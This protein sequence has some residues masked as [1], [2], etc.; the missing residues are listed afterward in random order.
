MPL[1]QCPDC[2]FVTK[3]LVKYNAHKERLADMDGEDV[4]ELFQAL[5][6]HAEEVF[7]EDA[8][9]DIFCD[10]GY[11]YHQFTVRVDDMQGKIFVYI[12][13]QD[14]YDVIHLAEL[15]LRY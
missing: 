10:D 11:Q 6:Y 12:V 3:S 8:F 5:L 2:W 14:G 13:N 9:H 15:P 1:Y 4:A 7:D